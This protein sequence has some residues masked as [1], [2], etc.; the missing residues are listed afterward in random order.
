M[1]SKRSYDLAFKQRV[2]DLA[3]MKGNRPAAAQLHVDEK[4]IRECRQ[5]EAAGKFS[6]LDASI[7]ACKASK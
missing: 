4:L 1:P 5:Q 3:K 2:V 7:G 6:D